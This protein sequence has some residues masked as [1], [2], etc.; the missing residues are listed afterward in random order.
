MS[1]RPPIYSP[2]NEFASWRGELVQA[3]DDDTRAA[4]D[5][6][7]EAA[8]AFEQATRGAL[9]V[10]ITRAADNQSGFIVKRETGHDR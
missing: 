7:I 10:Y 1:T 8:A 4:F 9:L 5:R 2:A 6:L 3:F